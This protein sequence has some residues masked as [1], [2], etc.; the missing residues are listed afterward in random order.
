MDDL[1][2][3]R[4]SR[5]PPFWNLVVKTHEHGCWVWQGK[6]NKGGYGYWGKVLA[7]RHSWMLANGPIPDGMWILHHCDNRPCVN[8]AHLYPGTVVENVRDM[9]SRGRNYVPALKTHCDRGHELSGDNLRLVGVDQRRICR[10]CD[11]DRSATRQREDR[12]ARGLR[13]TR[14]SDQDK[15]RICELRRDGLAHRR[16][17]VSVGRCL[18]SVQ[19]VLKEAG[20]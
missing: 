12:R 14:L 8:P 5:K 1:T 9:V 3:S 18:A 2:E 6:R 7:H 17:A 11:N 20:L 15:A 10:T 16:I 19:I 13:K 4:R